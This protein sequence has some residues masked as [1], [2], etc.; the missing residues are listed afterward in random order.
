M[1]KPQKVGPSKGNINTGDNRNVRCLQSGP[2][3]RFRK[4]VQGIPKLLCRPRA[5]FRSGS[6]V[7]V[8]KTEQN[9]Q[10]HFST[11]ISKS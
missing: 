3:T 11:P 8:S 7:L 4:P 1:A 2:T 5:M 10:E 9:Q 6:G